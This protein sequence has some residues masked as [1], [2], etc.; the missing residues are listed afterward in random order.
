MSLDILKQRLKDN[1]YPGVYLFYGKEEYTKNFYVT[2]LRKSINKSPLPEFNHILINAA[3]SSPQAL[4]EAVYSLP[5]MWDYKLIEVRNFEK[6]SVDS[7]VLEEY[8][9]VL[10]D[11]PDY[12]VLLFLFR[13][14][15]LDDSDTKPSKS[16]TKSKSKTTEDDGTK[17]TRQSRSKRGISAL[18]QGVRETGG[19][20]GF[21]P[22][23]GALREKWVVKQKQ[24]FRS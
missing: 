1:S 15:E 23:S 6:N 17:E 18:V 24:R 19:V 13:S 10:D 5:F 16:R 22:Q 20:G 4:T 2:Q 7:E 21:K 9:D 14:Q 11:L 8:I 12:V 3:E